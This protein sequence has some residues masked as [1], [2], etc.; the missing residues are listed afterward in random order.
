MLHVRN[1]TFHGVLNRRSEIKLIYNLLMVYL[2]QIRILCLYIFKMQIFVSSN[3]KQNIE[4]FKTTTYSCVKCTLRIKTCL[5]L[6]TIY[7][8][9]V[10][11][12][13]SYFFLFFS[14]LVFLHYYQ[15]SDSKVINQ[16]QQTIEFS[17]IHCNN[18]SLLF[19]FRGIAVVGCVVLVNYAENGLSLRLKLEGCY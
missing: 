7:N 3:L 10:F 6:S 19:S 11:S 2:N 9:N 5:N 14:F 13:F 16:T 15:T 18:R 12:S 4:D 1:K 17:S 8:S